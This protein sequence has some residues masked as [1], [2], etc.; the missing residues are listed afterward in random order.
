MNEKEVMAL[1]MGLAGLKARLGGLSGVVA[2][3][4]TQAAVR[5]WWLSIP[6]GLAIWGSIKERRES[7]KKLRLHHIFSDVGTIVAPV[8]SLAMLLNLANRKDTP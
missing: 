5:Y 7:G 4:L 3:P 1:K 8:V 6:A 2:N